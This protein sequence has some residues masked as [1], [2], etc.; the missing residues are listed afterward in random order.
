MQTTSARCRMEGVLLLLGGL[1]GTFGFAA[2]PPPIHH[3]AQAPGV[4]PSPQSTPKS[5]AVEYVPDLRVR[6]RTAL[7][8]GKLA[9]VGVGGDIDGVVNPTLRVQE[10]AVVQVDLLNDDGI[11]HDVAFPDF[12]AATERVAQKGASSVTVFRADTPGTFAYFCSV[13]GHRPAGMEG[14]LIVGTPRPA[15]PAP[16]LASLARVP[17]DLPGPLTPRPPTI[18]RVDL[19]AVEV[20]GRLDEET[21]YPYWTFNGQVPGP[22]VRVRVGDTVEVHVKNRPTSRMIH[23]VDFHAVTGPG[24]GAIL[25]QVPPGEVRV[26]TFQALNPGLYVYHCATPMVAHHVTSGMYGLILVEPEG[27]L[28]PVDREFYVMQGELYTQRPFGQHGPQEFSLEKLLAERA[29]Y[30]V[31]NG[32]V[33]AL[34]QAHP[35]EARVGE[36]VRI[37]FGVG[38]PNYLSSFHVIGEIFDRVYQQGAL[39]APPL[40]DVQTT[41]VPA[42]GAAMVEFRLE[43]PGRY[44]LVDHALARVERGLVGFLLVQGTENLS[45][46]RSGPAR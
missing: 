26:F 21:T 14:Q 25:T 1:A 41:L 36:T 40:T 43:V 27:G 31:F 7:A 10:G 37:F 18:V 29:E 3:V 8:E 4:A 5:P 32:A 38:G 12:D 11:E 44:I 23:S 22:F 33:G 16:A 6:L 20:V 13:P 17:T 15:A 35:L 9:F 28:P 34:T 42:G 45:V 24:G 39:T 30:L 46:F 2:A 19:E